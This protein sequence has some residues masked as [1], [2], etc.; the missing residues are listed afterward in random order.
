MIEKKDIIFK[1]VNGFGLVVYQISSNK[2]IEIPTLTERQQDLIEDKF[3]QY[4]VNFVNWV[5]H[6]N[7]RY[8]VKVTKEIID[9]FT[10]PKY[11]KELLNIIHNTYN[12]CVLD[13]EL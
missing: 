11:V 8:Y 10:F 9:G 13:V 7:R 4:M 1:D 6:S 12:D 2:I 3:Q 5:A